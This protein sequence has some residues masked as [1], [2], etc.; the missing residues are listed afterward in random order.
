MENSNKGLLV[1]IGAEFLLYALLFP[2][3]DFGAFLFI[4]ATGI[5][6]FVWFGMKN[7][8]ESSAREYKA[9]VKAEIEEKERITKLLSP[10]GD[11][12]GYRMKLD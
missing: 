7:S 10:K 3:S 5:T 12:F 8:R 4:F 2:D 11:R 1:I 6:I 9:Q